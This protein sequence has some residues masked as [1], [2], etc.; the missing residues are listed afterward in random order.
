MLCLVL[1]E[2]RKGKRSYQIMRYVRY[3]WQFQEGLGMGDHRVVAW[4]AINA[5]IGEPVRTDRAA[6]K[7]GSQ[8]GGFA[9]SA[10]LHELQ[11]MKDS[12]PDRWL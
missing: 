2:D 11:A 6:G 9:D 1:L 4:A 12:Q 10:T 5:E 8:L 3:N 7:A